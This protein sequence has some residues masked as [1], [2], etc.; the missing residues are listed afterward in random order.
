M[1]HIPRVISFW[2]FAV[3]MLLANATFAHEMTMA[4]IEL[5]ET[6][7]GE[8]L[9]QWTASGNLPPGDELTPV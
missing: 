2:A 5:R 1:T 4:E 7:P 3:L 6:A 8:F 9:W